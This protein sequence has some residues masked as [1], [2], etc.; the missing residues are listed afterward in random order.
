MNL[1]ILVFITFS[2]YEA[3]VI[4]NGVHENSLFRLIEKCTSK[5]EEGK[6]TNKLETV[7]PRHTLL[8]GDKSG[9]AY[10]AHFTLPLPTQPRLKERG[11]YLRIP[12]PLVYIHDE[13]ILRRFIRRT[14]DAVTSHNVWGI[15]CHNRD[16]TEA[17][18][19]GELRKL[20]SSSDL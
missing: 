19:C 1:Y 2:F 8:R 3:F 12:R 9:S 16:M 17:R 15:A 10:L 14:S 11:E 5:T 18:R 7:S 20:R 4:A 6:K 13:K